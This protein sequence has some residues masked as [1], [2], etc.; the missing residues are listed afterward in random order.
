MASNRKAAGQSEER[1]QKIF[2]TCPTGIAIVS[3]N[4]DRWLYINPAMAELFGAESVEQLWKFDLKMTYANSAD[5]DLMRSKAGDDFITEA[6]VERVRLDGTKLWCLLNRSPIEYEGQ[7]ALIVWHHD[8]TK[9]K[10]G[11]QR[12]LRLSEE[13][14]HLIE[15][16][17]S[18]LGESDNLFH[19]AFDQNAVGMAIRDVGPHGPKWLRV[20]QKFCE[21]FRY[22]REEMLQLTPI[23][24]SP[25][26]EKHAAV[27]LNE[28]IIQGKIKSYSGE[29]RYMRKN[30]DLFWANIWLSSILGPDGHPTH[31]IQ[32]IQDITERKHAEEA[33]RESE[34]RLTHLAATDPLTGTDNRR[35]FFEKGEKELRRAGRYKRPISL[36]ML[37]IDNFKSVND[38]HGHAFGDRVL[39]CFVETCRGILRE[40]DVLGRLG[41]EEFA[42][43]LVEENLEAGRLVAER[44]R[45]AVEALELENAY[46]TCRVT[47]S[48]GVCGWA[49][50]PESLNKA[51][52][53][54]DK[55]LYAAKMDGRNRVIVMPE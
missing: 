46:V 26:E 18:Q 49:G 39:Q 54:A 15:A 20:N 19:A 50:E 31:I 11:E 2:N 33:L 35:S 47:I 53:R 42:V 25:P 12:I 32:V 37:D 24:V 55:A 17:T 4:T 23:D 40:Q 16:R 21:I 44:L 6:E 48:I 28:R 30:G 22:T 14:E 8:I 36:L 52:E 27:D 1:F 7:D 5:L 13:L 43:V 29:K 51:L 41:G 45:R 34:S 3:L 38:T 9:R 10:E